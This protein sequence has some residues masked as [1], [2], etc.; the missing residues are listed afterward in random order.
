MNGEQRG[1]LRRPGHAVID[2]SLDKKRLRRFHE[3]DGKDWE[4]SLRWDSRPADLRPL[5][6]NETGPQ[7]DGRGFRDAPE[8]SNGGQHAYKVRN[9]LI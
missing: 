3:A 8:G 9:I 1:S 7:H 2:E 4:H 6:P 5:L